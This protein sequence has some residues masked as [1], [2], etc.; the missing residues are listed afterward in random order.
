[1]SQQRPQRQ[2]E[3]DDAPAW[4][5][6]F[7]DMIT[8]LLSFFILLQAF[9][10][11]QDPELFNVGRESF[12]RAISGM[13]IPGLLFG[14]GAQMPFPDRKTKYTTEEAKQKSP[15]N[16]VLDAEAEKI[17]KTFEKLQNSMETRSSDVTEKVR[18]R[19]VTE[20]KFAPSRQD[21]DE[22]TKSYLSDLAINLKQNLSRQA[23]I[24]VY[25]IGLAP[26]ASDDRAKW[27]LSAGRAMAVKNFLA[28]AC[29]AG[30][31]QTSG[32]ALS[33]WEFVCWGAGQGSKW[34]QK[35]GR[36]PGES[37]IVIVV[38]EESN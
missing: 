6:S 16:R 12:K 31:G 29:Q 38:T 1:M 17:A 27:Y 32:S 30:P 21:L 18:Y 37:Y 3:K 33:R 7:A 34:L 19:R 23:G 14:K 24:T 8:L 5:V 36:I 2:Q 35:L 25:V 26:D 9:A 28:D 11:M 20:I 13:G 10:T 22:F 15:R 4:I